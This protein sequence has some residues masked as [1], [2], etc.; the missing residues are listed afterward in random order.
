MSNPRQP[1]TADSATAEEWL[2]LFDSTLKLRSPEYQAAA[3]QMA[4]FVGEQ[5]GFLRMVSVRD[6]AGQGLTAC[7]WRSLDD[8]K[9]WKQHAAHL[10]VQARGKQA[11][12]SSYRVTIAR[13]VKSHASNSADTASQTESPNPATPGEALWPDRDNQSIQWL[14][15]PFDGLSPRQVHAV[16][17]LRAEAFV[18][19][20]GCAYVDPDEADLTSHYVMG[21]QG[22]RLV[23]SCRIL[24]PLP[25]PEWQRF[26]AMHGCA[27]AESMLIP[28]SPVIG[29]VVTSSTVR[30]T[31]LGRT[32]MAKA[33]E[34]AELLYP[35]DA[36]FLGAQAHLRDFYASFGF[37]I[38]G[39]PFLEDRIP[40]LAMLRQ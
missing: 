31:S 6:E 20:Q 16:L 35:G 17:R 24:P 18:L 29:R 4:T 33:V 36:V 13:V 10:A 12:Y 28:P 25:P 40:H 37:K 26:L 5:P 32:L 11:W 7:F 22:T 1:A 30:G 27:S 9:A 23:A 2:V 21:W 34:Q 3:E 19:E 14:T 15:C 38:V 39:E 8:I